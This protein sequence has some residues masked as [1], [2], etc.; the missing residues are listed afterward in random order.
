LDVR[1]TPDLIEEGFV[2]E[3]ISKVQTMRKDCNFDIMD[4]INLFHSGNDRIAAIMDRHAAR[5]ADEVLANRIEQGTGPNSRDW[6]LNG[7]S[8]TLS[9]E[10]LPAR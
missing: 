7:E 4:R 3:I 10:R 2:R 5:I 8:C 1:L 6:D 9:V